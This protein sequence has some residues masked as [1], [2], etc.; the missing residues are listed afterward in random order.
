MSGSA[1]EV[2]VRSGRLRGAMADGVAVFRAIPFAAPPFGELRFQVPQPPAPWD[3]VRPATERGPGAP[4]PAAPEDPFDR[5]FNPP[6]TGPDCLTLDVWTPD[7]GGSGLP[8]MVWIHGGGYLTGTGS[9]PAHDGTTFARDGVV[10]VAINYRLNVDGFLHFEGEP[11][12]RGLRDQVAA[13]G[14]VQENIAAFGGDPGRVTIF[15][16]SGGGVSVL[17]LLAMPAARGLFGR[18]IAQS[19]STIATVTPDEALEWTR[20][21]A[22]VLGVAPTAAGFASVDVERAVAAVM[23]L[24]FEFINPAVSGGQAFTISPF[25]AVLD[26]ETLPEQV[27]AAVAAGA[28]HDV[29]L[30][31][32]TTRD[33]TSG[34]MRLLGQ[35]DHL[36][37]GWADSALRAFGLTVDDLETYRKA[38]RPNAGTTELIQAAWTDWAFRIPTLRLLEAHGGRSFGYEFTWSSPALPEGFGSDH[39]LEIPFVRDDLAAF[40]AVGPVAEAVLGADAPRQLA[41]AMHRAWVDFATHGDPGWAPYEVPTR[42]TMRFD[43]ESAAV[44]DLA[45]AERELWVTTP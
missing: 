43:V 9:A 44:D 30:L 22:E 26:G 37:E 27:Q 42:T 7:P 23:P 1:V 24:A 2:Q 4:Q 19:G 21:L 33:E 20:R 18:A 40:R 45:G 8:V 14:W 15:G 16:Q 34:F 36:D 35:L 13:L 10:H 38:S 5:Y 31:A 12:N 41:T 25:R 3:G 17:N 39:A 32:A 6:S 11:A 28:A 29:D